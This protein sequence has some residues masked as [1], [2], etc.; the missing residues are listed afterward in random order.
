MMAWQALSAINID[1]SVLG[2]ILFVNVSTRSYN[3][4]LTTISADR[5]VPLLSSLY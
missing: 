4:E 3:V 1:L 5:T 2:C